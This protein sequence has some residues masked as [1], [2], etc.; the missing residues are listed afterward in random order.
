MAHVR[1]IG[2]A[3]R[4]KIE[5]PKV[6][7]GRNAPDPGHVV[8]A[9]FVGTVARFA[10]TCGHRCFHREAGAEADS[11]LQVSNLTRG[12][13]SLNRS[14]TLVLVARRHRKI[15]AMDDINAC[16]RRPRTVTEGY[17]CLG[18]PAGRRCDHRT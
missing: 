10:I 12:R 7:T 3:S 8:I 5:I 16:P 9:E 6:Y 4:L 14:A 17:C 11:T 2:R 1:V 15:K 13:L 18:S